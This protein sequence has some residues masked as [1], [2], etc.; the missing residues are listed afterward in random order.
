MTKSDFYLFR[1]EF[2][3]FATQNSKIKNPSHIIDIHNPENFTISKFS[4]SQIIHNP[5]NFNIPEIHYLTV[6][7]PDIMTLLILV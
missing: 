3:I 5:E 4:Q 2:V 6:H 7:Y 1:T